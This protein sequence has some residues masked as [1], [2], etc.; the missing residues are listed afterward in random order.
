MES[1]MNNMYPRWMWEKPRVAF[2]RNRD[3]EAYNDARKNYNISENT[4]DILYNIRKNAIWNDRRSDDLIFDKLACNL[5]E[6]T[7][8]L[9]YTIYM[10]M[11]EDGKYTRYTTHGYVPKVYISVRTDCDWICARDEHMRIMTVTWNQRKD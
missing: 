8:D 10:K 2:D 7:Y 1:L 5:I 11:I 9:I 3:Q 4:S 6:L